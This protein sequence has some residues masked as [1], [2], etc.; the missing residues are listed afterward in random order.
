MSERRRTTAIRLA[1]AGICLAAAAAGFDPTPASAQGPPCT[2]DEAFHALDF[3]RGE[4]TVWV[5]GTRVGTN[6]IRA[7]QGGC[8][9]EEHWEDVNGGTGQSLFYYLPVEAVWKQVW[10]TPGARVAGGVKE[11]VGV[12]GAPEGAVRFRGTIRRAD[13]VTYED[14]T[15]LTPLP[16]GRVRQHIEISTDGGASWRTTFDAE[17]RPAGG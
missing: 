15:T 11:K 4:W 6:R 5:D 17:Y 14:R 1:T 13:G 9:V 2:A 12:D 3:W 8:A 16:G 7:V 10:V